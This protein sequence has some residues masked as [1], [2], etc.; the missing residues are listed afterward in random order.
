VRRDH[1][2]TK[3]VLTCAVDFAFVSS[4]AMRIWIDGALEA[5]GH[6]FEHGLTSDPLEHN[7]IGLNAHAAIKDVR[8]WNVPLEMKELEE[9][10]ENIKETYE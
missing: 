2:T 10:E 5:I 8:V 9:L 7:T 3:C 4:G 6:G 1:G